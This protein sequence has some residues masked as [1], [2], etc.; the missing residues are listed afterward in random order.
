MSSY[1][2][3]SIEDFHVCFEYESEEDPIQGK[4]GKQSV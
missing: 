3:P 2:K 4:W 1:Y